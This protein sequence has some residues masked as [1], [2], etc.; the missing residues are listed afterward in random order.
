M[1]IQKLVDYAKI[2]SLIELIHVIHWDS[3]KKK[4]LNSRSEVWK[5]FFGMTKTL[6]LKAQIKRIV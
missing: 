4:N 3:K 5:L 6:H 2:I 1:M